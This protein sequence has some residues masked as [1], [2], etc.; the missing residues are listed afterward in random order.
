MSRKL[1]G[2]RR[3]RNK[4]QV[5]VTVG[6]RQYTKTFP[7][8][9][10]VDEMRTWRDDQVD[11]HRAPGAAPA[12]GSFGDDIVTY[13][14]RVSA[15]RSI[16]QRTAHL[17]RWAQELGRTRS[18]RSITPEE[19]EI[20][21]QGW[22]DTPTTPDPG[23][24]GRPSGPDGLA[25][26]TVRKRRTALQSFFAKMDGKKSS[27]PNPVKGTDAPKVPP[28]AARSLDYLS[29]ERALT[30]MPEHCSVKPGTEKPLSLS[31]IRARVLAYTGL[32]PGLLQT[33]GP[34]DLH[35][36]A[37]TVRVR[38]R[39]KGKGVEARTLPLTADGV[40]AFTAFHEANAYGTFATSALNVVFKR[41]W[42][43]AGLT[44]TDVTL[45]DL[46]HSF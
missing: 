38:P 35:L 23:Q 31:K 18:R 14:A 44:P 34:A 37:A 9:T 11:T 33:I 1:K 25:P 17:E 8:T 28:V 30:A 42:K 3:K 43:R 6:G 15:M 21:L 39:R 10:P 24:R 5:H 7:L 40:A 26:G 4:W 45:Y 36:H 16:K 19:I 46:R 32:P 29:I 27:Y 22:L 13:L 12:G 20:I 41:A 2:I